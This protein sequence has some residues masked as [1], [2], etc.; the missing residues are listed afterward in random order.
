M[1]ARRRVRGPHLQ[2]R[3]G[4]YY[5]Y[6]SKTERPSLHTRDEAEAKR[7]FAERL[8]GASPDV[9]RAAGAAEVPLADLT[10]KYLAAPHGWTKQTLRSARSRVEMIGEWFERRGVKRASAITPALVD[11]YLTERRAEVSHRTINRDWRAWR[12]ALEWAA[13][14]TLCAPCPAVSGRAYLRE[15]KRTKRRV[16][17]SPAEVM[18]VIDWLQAR[19][20]SYGNR[21]GSPKGGGG[22][23]PRRRIGAI[24]TATLYAT[25]L[26][27]DELRRVTVGDLHDGAIWVR[28]EEG[29]AD[30]SE[31]TKGHRERAIP[32]APG[33]QALVRQYLA[34]VGGQTR[35]W[36]ETWLLGV[37]YEAC[38]KTGVPAFA[39]H[40]LRRAFATEAHRAGTPV[41]VIS[42]WLGHADVRTTEL[43]LGAYR[44]DREVVAPVPGELADAVHSLCTTPV[45]RGRS[46]STRRVKR[47]ASV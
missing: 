34:R 9:R 16:V 25:G 47:S 7:L 29:A 26:R 36:S 2:K 21:S 45:H 5:A 40:D 13:E 23:G 35:Q 41:L 39:V 38:E 33:A 32:L 42:R 46:E 24:V 19:D 44:T 30:A 14:R 8:S 6:L 1:P 10:A 15:A 43:Y 3:G 22:N 37:L 18:R 31:P 27:V 11:A 4:I 12:L 17:P 20:A 28:P